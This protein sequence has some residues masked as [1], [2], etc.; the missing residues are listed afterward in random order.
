MNKD[1]QAGAENILQIEPEVVV[2][3][4]LTGS[5]LLYDSIYFG[6]RD[7]ARAQVQAIMDFFGREDEWIE[8]I[9][10]FALLR[11]VA[12]MAMRYAGVPLSAVH[13]L[14]QDYRARALKLTEREDFRRLS[15]DFVDACCAMVTDFRTCFY[16]PAIVK[17][18]GLILSDFR[19][20]LKV[21]E[22]AEI[23]GLNPNHLSNQFRKETGESLT[24]YLK[25]VRL[26]YAMRL[27]Q[28]SNLS[29]SDIA[30]EVGFYDQSHFS[31]VFRERYGMTPLEY[32]QKR[33][34]IP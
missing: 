3:G 25:D 20:P 15:L 9:D 24:A 5:D 19:R 21:S 8:F 14:T 29:L 7:Q 16:S 11:A 22:I 26:S 4:K 17:A 34:L 1:K 27:L 18:V 30:L 6:N 33:Y 31:R 10:H 23:L 13:R 2:E 32:R 12:H 28:I